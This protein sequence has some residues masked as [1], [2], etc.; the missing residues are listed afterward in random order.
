MQENLDI[1]KDRLDF[2]NSMVKVKH[3]CYYLPWNA[4]VA[5]PQANQKR[6]VWQKVAPGQDAATKLE[7]PSG[8]KTAESGCPGSQVNDK[9]RRCLLPPLSPHSGV[10]L[11]NQASTASQPEVL[12]RRKRNSP[13]SLDNLRYLTRAT[14]VYSGSDLTAPAKDAAHGPVREVNPE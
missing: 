1:D 4:V 12:T 2:S 8:L 14:S 11:R 9:H 10:T 7:G 5:R 13:L 3:L 6:R